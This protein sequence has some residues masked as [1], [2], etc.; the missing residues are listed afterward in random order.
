MSRATCIAAAGSALATLVLV[1]AV[2]SAQAPPV[3]FQLDPSQSRISI[4]GEGYGIEA[5][6]QGPGS[7]TATYAGNLLVGLDDLMAPALIEFVGGEATAANNGSWLPNDVLGP[8]PGENSPN[9]PGDSAPANYGILID[10]NIV[11]TALLGDVNA[12]GQVNGLDV[13]PFVDLLLQNQYELLADMNA[14]GKLNGLDVDPFVAAVVGGVQ[15]IPEPSTLVLT[16]VALGVVGG[17]RR[18]LRHERMVVKSAYHHLTDIPFAC[19]QQKRG[20]E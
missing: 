20:I 14:D 6:E 19:P 3:A 7:L 5:T 8:G 18:Q 11:A 9:H 1:S 10:G 12:D 17:W 4:A 15:Q 13:D 2:A 16:L